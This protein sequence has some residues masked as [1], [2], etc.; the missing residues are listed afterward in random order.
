[1]PVLYPQDGQNYDANI[2]AVLNYYG[3]INYVVNQLDDGEKLLTQE[4]AFSPNQVL[5]NN[6]F[7]VLLQSGECVI[8]GRYYQRGVSYTSQT[9]DRSNYS[10]PIPVHIEITG[11]PP[12]F[13]V[14]LVSKPNN[15]VQIGEITEDA[16]GELI[17]NPAGVLTGSERQAEKT[18]AGYQVPLHSEFHK[19]DG[20]DDLGDDFVFSS[21]GSFTKNQTV[22]VDQSSTKTI[23]VNARE[24]DYYDDVSYVYVN[25]VDT[26]DDVT[27][28]VSDKSDIENIQISVQNN[29]SNQKSI[30]LSILIMADLDK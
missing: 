26:T 1:M 16:N 24:Q 19:F 25:T 17:I 20:I 21:A 15:N 7:Q 27:A 13:K 30:K 11:N 22:T 5:G 23:N 2:E 9:F 14:S 3:H 12:S 4:D 6:Q 8:N 10:T 18:E 28:T 29:T